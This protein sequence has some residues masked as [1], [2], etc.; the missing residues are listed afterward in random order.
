V[1]RAVADRP[2]ASA[3][4]LATASGVAKP[5]LYNLLRRLSER[6]ELVKQELP[7]GGAGYALPGPAG[8]SA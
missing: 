3:G 6:G 2:G 5:V 7:G 4:E 1:L 8:P